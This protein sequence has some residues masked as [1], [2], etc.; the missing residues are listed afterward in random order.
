MDIN[1]FQK[2]VENQLFMLHD[3]TNFKTDYT[4][5]ENELL[6]L[7]TIRAP[8]KEND[9]WTEIYSFLIELVDNKLNTMMDTDPHTGELVI[10]DPNVY[11]VFGLRYWLGVAYETNSSQGLQ[12]FGYDFYLRAQTQSIIESY[13]GSFNNDDYNQFSNELAQWLYDDIIKHDGVLSIEKIVMADSLSF[14]KFHPDIK[15]SDWPGAPVDWATL[16]G[17]HLDSSIEFWIIPPAIENYDEF[18]QYEID[19]QAYFGNI[20]KFDIWSSGVIYYMFMKGTT[21]FSKLIDNPLTVFGSIIEF[22]TNIN[23]F[24][25]S[26]S[27]SQ[28]AEIGDYLRNPVKIF[29]ALH[30]IIS[31]H[32]ENFTGYVTLN[33]NSNFM[34]NLYFYVE[35]GRITSPL[36]FKS[37]EEVLNENN[38]LNIIFGS[39]EDD[40]INASDT[41]TIIVSLKGSDTLLGGAGSD[42]LISGDE[43]DTLDGGAGADFLQGGQ[44]NDTYL[45]EGSDIIYDSDGFGTIKFKNGNQLANLFVQS[46]TEKNVWYSIDSSGNKS[47]DMVATKFGDNLVIK[48]GKDSVSIQHFF[49]D[50]EQSVDGKHWAYLGINLDI[51]EENQ[52]PD[53]TVTKSA[54]LG[55][56]NYF[57]IAAGQKGVVQLGTEGDFVNADGA[58]TITVYGGEG[59]DLI[60]GSK[61]ADYLKGGLDDDVI[62]G[63]G[64]LIVNDTAEKQALDKDY[65]IGGAGS[66]L[67]DGVVGDDI[68]FTGEQEEY[69]VA[70]NLNGKGDWAVGGLGNDRIYGSSQ[71]DALFGGEGEDIIHGGAGDD[72]IL[73]DGHVRFSSA[74]QN[75]P[76]DAINHENTTGSWVTT[77][78][79][80]FIVYNRDITK[81]DFV[82]DS[83]NGDY[84][85][86]NHTPTTN[87]HRVISGGGTDILYGGMGG[88]LIIG[89]DGNDFLFGEEGDDILYGDDN[90]DSSIVGNDYLDGGMGNDRLY[91]GDGNDILIAGTG[92]DFLYGGLGIDQYDF[93]TKDL[94]IA[95]DVNTIIDSD[96][97][98]FITL[99]G[100]ELSSIIWKP[101]SGEDNLWQSKDKKLSLSLNNSTLVLTGTDFPAKIVIENFKNGDLD[102]KLNSAPVAQNTIPTI[103]VHEN[104]TWS[105][106][107]SK[108]AFNDVDDD[109]LVYSVKQANGN[110]LPYWI[111]FNP[112]TLTLSGSKP[113]L[114][115]F[116]LKLVAMDPYGEKAEIQFNLSVLK[117]TNDNHA[118]Q[119]QLL[120]GN[121]NVAEE[122]E[123][124]YTLSDQL[125]SD[126]DGDALAYQVKQANGS[127]LPA[128][129][130][131][132][133]TTKQL[134]GTPTGDDVGILDLII[135]ATD[136]KGETAQQSFSLY[137]VDDGNKFVFGLAQSTEQN[138]VFKGFEGADTYA[139]SG[140]WGKDTIIDTSH[141]NHMYFS[142]VTL[143]DVAFK[144]VGT[145]LYITKNNS[146]DSIRIRNQF[147]DATSTEAQTIV[148]WEFADGQILKPAIINEILQFE[149]S[150]ALR[151]QGTSEDDDLIGSSA[152]E[153]IYGGFGSDVIN[154]GGGDDLLVGGYGSDTYSY[155]GTW[156]KDIIIDNS[157]DNHMYFRDMTLAE[158]SFQRDGTD[159]LITKNSGTD[160]IRIKNQYANATLNE[161]QVIVNL[162]FAD[163]QILKPNQIEDLLKAKANGSS[164][165]FGTS[166]D[167]D[168]VGSIGNDIIYGGYG[169]DV[170]NG[171]SG[172]DVLIGGADA[173]TY[174][175]SGNWGKDTIIDFGSENHMYF[176]DVNRADVEFVRVGTDLMINKINTTDSIMIRNQYADGTSNDANVIVHWEF[177]DG[178]ELDATGINNSIT[179]GHQNAARQMQIPSATSGN[180][181]YSNLINAMASMSSAESAVIVGNS[182]QE[183]RPVLAVSA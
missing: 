98:G 14:Q 95:S 103:S 128:W 35:N 104:E 155:S 142:D 151:I 49:R 179:I 83:V 157:A 37:V 138:E 90:R 166:D 163:G 41:N 66:D 121:I 120:Q 139:F 154:G 23:M 96:G 11:G 136:P 135:I 118:P 91:G 116:D 58:S 85:L 64:V 68:I 1:N 88:D 57:K 167:D 2:E 101:V 76:L 143:A 12:G 60:Y 46:I 52:T 54:T 8:I 62:I 176:S 44:G 125:F 164:T 114:G 22:K 18:E 144:R 89:Q 25:E 182:Y 13:G 40:T 124:S 170:L 112:I 5:T 29:D 34:T 72:V 61:N 75:R 149:S 165:V 51:N 171:S 86:V 113:I 168:I 17:D 177:A 9:R 94:Q 140:T 43:N 32:K 30:E 36:S 134:L 71:R 141:D 146:T 110:S 81:W 20:K 123:F 102:L 84:Q 28:Q 183:N 161:A 99:D 21:E 150:G 3:Q 50:A 122:E 19:V 77:S 55:S 38:K 79:E 92:S 4:L 24:S 26:I 82:I 56:F 132:N 65:I 133:P 129:L 158:V 45:I 100:I 27:S 39:S 127:P 106:T 137:V 53:P 16:G 162:E 147:L 130:S 174:A 152:N 131:F 117:E 119:T 105:Y 67:I 33:V 178:V 148:N 78:S 70:S 172:D 175:F 111:K 109:A 156:G 180:L 73:G 7:K 74:V 31:F 169:Y 87:S 47:G 97:H 145:D 126:E 160:S 173:D 115:N 63:A 181:G 48:S 159:L 93:Y 6:K 42:T 10:K 107:L 80:Y 69:L 15:Q 59:K 153:Y 108:N